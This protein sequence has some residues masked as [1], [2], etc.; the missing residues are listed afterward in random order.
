MRLPLK[1]SW[2]LSQTRWASI[3]EPFI[4]NPFNSGNL[5]KDIN[6]AN[7]VTNIDHTLGRMQQGWVI[8]DI[9][10]SAWVYRSAPFN[11]TTLQLT[12]NGEVTVNLYVF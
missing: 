12:S 9:N 11:D 3:L 1:L 5:L 10:G 2:D 8:T 7:G 6:L 4:S